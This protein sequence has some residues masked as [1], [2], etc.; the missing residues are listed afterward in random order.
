MGDHDLPLDLVMLSELNLTSGFGGLKRLERFWIWRSE[1]A[2]DLGPERKQAGIF[3]F[4]EELR[5]VNEH[6]ER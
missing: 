4:R 1:A 3:P 2:Y 6:A 5:L